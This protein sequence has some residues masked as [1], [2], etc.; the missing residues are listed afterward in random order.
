MKQGNDLSA[1]IR[2]SSVVG[3]LLLAACICGWTQ[4]KGAPASQGDPMAAAVQELQEQVRQLRAAVVE[5]R[6]EAAQYRAETADL[7]RE[8]EA[9]RS[10]RQTASSAVSSA[11]PTTENSQPARASIEERVATLEESSQLVSSKVD[12]QYQ[13]KVESASKYRV[14]LSGL[15]LLNL[16]GNRGT[17]DNLDFPVV[18]TP[19]TPYSPRATLGGSLR[20]SE[21]GLEVFGPRLAGARTSGNLR[22]D[23]AGGF[24]NTPNGVNFG[25]VRLRIATARL[26][27]EKTSLVV[28]QDNAF[29]SPLSPTS[30]AS[31]AVPT[32]GYAGNLWGWIPQIRVEHRFDFSPRQSITLQGGILDNQ[33]GEP[34][35]V[36]SDRAPQAGERSGQPAYGARAAWTRNLFGQAMSLGA[37]GYYSRQDWG[38]SRHVDG[39]AGMADWEIPVAPRIS[40]S[41]EFYRGLAMGGLGGGIGRSVLFSGSPSDPNAQI[42]ALDS[43]GGWSQLKVKAS[44]KLE[45]NGAFGLDNPFA[46]DLRAFPAIQSYFDPFLQQNRS[47]FVN[48]VYRPRSDLLLSAEYRH[49]RSFEIDRGSQAAQQVNLMMGIL[50]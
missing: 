25:L 36:L 6:S 30:F 14:R 33:T 38:F 28:G 45:F 47:A 32:F 20:Q 26:D 21:I 42:R 2:K 50:F 23:F 43:V 39:W 1:G 27:W 46:E 31:I 40:L 8:L 35:F 44:S 7:R 4:E 18:V 9:A 48:F 29:V 10:Q 5:M 24:P 15:V 37:A 22:V 41:G 16:F 3:V 17:T 13:T 12:D 11:A 49:L 34:P 19:S